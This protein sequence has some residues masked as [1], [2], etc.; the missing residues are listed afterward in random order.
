MQERRSSVA[1]M[2]P[3]LGV[4]SIAATCDGAALLA[5]VHVGGIP[6]STDSGLTWRPTIDIEAD[7]HEVCAHPTRPEI[8][9]AAAGAGKTSRQSRC[10]SDMEHR[11]ARTSRPSLLRC[12]FWEK[13][14]FRVGIHRPFCDPRRSISTPD[15]QQRS[16][17]AFGRRYAE[18]DRRQSRYR[19]HRGP[20]FNGRRNRQ[21]GTPLRV[22]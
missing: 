9:I 4:R 22:A 2:G 14:H 12:C 5:N 10:W 8:V 20:K 6:Q 18:M 1:V 17:A 7:V 11:T 13:R 21:L 3:P 19:L 15:R 16:V